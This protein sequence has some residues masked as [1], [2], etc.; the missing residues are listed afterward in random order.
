MCCLLLHNGIPED[1]AEA[2]LQKVSLK[3][4]ILNLVF[5]SICLTSPALA[6]AKQNDVELAAQIRADQTLHEV[7]GMAT[8]ILKGGA[9]AGSGYKQTWIRDFN[10][11]IEVA[12]GEARRP[13]RARCS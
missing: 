10:T 7:H 1:Q 12:L 6:Q 3:E 4:M 8:E 13:A 2:K 5:A 11:F 9:N